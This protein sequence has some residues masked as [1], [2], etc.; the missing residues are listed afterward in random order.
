MFKGVLKKS[1][2]RG[3]SYATLKN[4]LKNIKTIDLKI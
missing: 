1:K 3:L 2:D 4:H